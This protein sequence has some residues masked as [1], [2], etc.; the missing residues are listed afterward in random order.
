MLGLLTI[1]ICLWMAKRLRRRT[2]E[3]RERP[4]AWFAGKRALRLGILLVTVPLLLFLG[5]VRF[6]HGAGLPSPFL[7]V[8]CVGLCTVVMIGFEFEITGNV[9][10][11]AVLVSAGLVACCLAVLNGI[12]GAMALV[13]RG[14]TGTWLLFCI[15]MSVIVRAFIWLKEGN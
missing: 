8:V 11:D 5:M 7:F 3:G 4:G 10:I 1:I 14:G 2:D 15:L 13:R 6:T 12:P 9:L